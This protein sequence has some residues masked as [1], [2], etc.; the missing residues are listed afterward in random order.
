MLAQSKLNSTETVISLAL[1]G[2][3][4]SHKEFKTIVND[5]KSMKKGKK[6]LK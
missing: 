5:K 6:T 1:I 2:L 4:I 3:E